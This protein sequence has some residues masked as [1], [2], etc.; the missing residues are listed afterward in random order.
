MCC[1][2]EFLLCQVVEKNSFAS[3]RSTDF[4]SPYEKSA[5]PLIDLRAPR[6]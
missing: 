4:A 2:I 1:A 5:P 3:L 6:N